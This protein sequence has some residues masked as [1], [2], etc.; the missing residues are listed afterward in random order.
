MSVRTTLPQ[1]I[2][3]ML[4][5]AAAAPF[6]SLAHV[7]EVLWDGVRALAFVEQG[8]VRLQDR[9]GR[10]VTQRY[11]E[12]SSLTGRLRESGMVIDGEIVC[13]H[14]DGRP[15]FATLRHRLAVDDAETARSLA[16]QS[17]VTL[18]A[19]DLVYRERQAV[20]G[21]ALRRRKEM[22]RSLVR[23]D[24]TIAVP[25]SVAKDGVAF[26]E[27]VREHGLEGIVAKEA[28][29]RYLPGQ[30][31][32]AWLTVRAQQKRDFIVGGFTYGGRWN[33]R[34][35]S[36]PREAISS[37]LVGLLREDGQLDFAGEVSG[38]FQDEMG[39]L[40]RRLDETTTAACQFAE[41]PALER[42]VF[43]CRPEVVAAI[44]YAEPAP[45]GRLRFPVF[46]ALRADVPPDSCRVA[47]AE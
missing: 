9:W 47:E 37:L 33:P 41:E 45:D 43:W 19:F 11:P 17:P 2:E 42:L 23:S 29:S 31:S 18:Q 36:R 10:D 35:G 39:E 16:E 12:L 14:T 21:W 38:G 30:R 1:V 8:N 25:D 27:A 3:P 44:T 32:R 26:F 46:K 15:D 22:L 13:L 4:P 6:D 40:V 24:T 20:T 5:A 7:F 28:D 34:G